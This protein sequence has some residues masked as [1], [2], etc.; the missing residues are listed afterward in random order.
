MIKEGLIDDRE[1]VRAVIPE[2]LYN[3]AKSAIEIASGIMA[4]FFV[5]GGLVY[6][7]APLAIQLADITKTYLEA[8]SRLPVAAKKYSGIQAPFLAQTGKGAR[9]NQIKLDLNEI[10]KLIDQYKKADRN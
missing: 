4:A 2:G 8:T 10:E 9:L 7:A 3:K 5:P 1:G 6:G